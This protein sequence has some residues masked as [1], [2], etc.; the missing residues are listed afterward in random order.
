M[1]RLEGV[2]A[3]NTDARAGEAAIAERIVEDEVDTFCKWLAG[4]D[5]VPTMVQLREKIES[6]REGE[7]SRYL[8]SAGASLDD[9]QREGIERLT[10]TIVNK[11][12]HAPL[13]ELRR[14]G[15]PTE[16]LYIDAVRVLF[17][18]GVGHA[19]ENDREPDD[20]DE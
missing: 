10:R 3:D 19:G 17:R 4:L 11:I 8:A 7:I 14:R 2:I 16:T 5:A 6:I 13:S 15:T 12:L 9:R 1:A 18:L 20:E